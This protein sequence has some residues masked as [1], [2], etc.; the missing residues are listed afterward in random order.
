MILTV[1]FLVLIVLLTTIFWQVCLILAAVTGSP[2][3][4]ANKAAVLKSLELAGIK[5]GE[6]M[7]DLGCGDGRTLIMAAQKFGAKGIG[8]DR[9]LWCYIKSNFNIFVSGQSKNI[10]IIRGDFQKAGKDLKTADVVYLYLLNQTLAQ[11]ESWLFDSIGS[12]TRVVS[13]AFVFPNKKPTKEAD[14][15]TLRQ[16]TKARLYQK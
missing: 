12:K 16:W 5:P 2:I 6:T 10:K 15:Y 13:L 4:Y 9:S 11:I 7:I 8:V 14:A 1:E 3:V